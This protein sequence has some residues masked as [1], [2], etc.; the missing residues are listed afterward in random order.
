MNAEE[1]LRAQGEAGPAPPS[2]AVKSPG[3]AMPSSAG[4]YD[5]RQLP[6]ASR[7]SEVATPLQPSLSGLTAGGAARAQPSETGDHPMSEGG[8][9]G[10]ASPAVSEPASSRVRR[11][12]GASE[13]RTTRHKSSG[14]G[15]ERRTETPGG[16]SAPPAGASGEKSETSPT[17]RRIPAQIVYRRFNNT[18]NELYDFGVEINTIKFIWFP[19][20]TIK[21][22]GEHVTAESRKTNRATPAHPTRPP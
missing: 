21:S 12:S 5:G 1:F 11:A 6:P 20:L 16:G 2:P 22:S 8:P 10:R 7:S 3:A 13:S 15:M 19:D 14:A 18:S 4:S 17:P 9:S